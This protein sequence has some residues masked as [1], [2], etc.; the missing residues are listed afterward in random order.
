M[1]AESKNRMRTGT[2][3]VS[4]CTPVK[5][6]WIELLH[7]ENWALANSTLS[8]WSW[9]GKVAMEE[10]KQRLYSD[11][12]SIGQKKT[13]VN[14]ISLLFSGVSTIWTKIWIARIHSKVISNWAFVCTFLASSEYKNSRIRGA[15]ACMKGVETERSAVS[16]ISHTKVTDFMRT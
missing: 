7:M 6:V 3:S 15:K 5:N 11:L 4:I 16:K 10:K 12:K 9:N 14:Q 2:I 1:W 13:L 8:Q